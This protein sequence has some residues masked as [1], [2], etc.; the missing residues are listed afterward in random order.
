M[1]YKG[2]VIDRP[3]LAIIGE[4]IKELGCNFEAGKVYTF[5][6]RR[7]WREKDGYLIE[8]IEDAVER[9]NKKFP[10]KKHCVSKKSFRKKRW[11]TKRRTAQEKANKTFKEEHPDIPYKEQ[12][13]DKR[14]LVFRE[15]ILAK[16]GHVCE[17]CGLTEHLQIHHLRYKTR[18]YAWEYKETDVIV[19]CAFCHAKTHGKASERL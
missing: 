5:W 10:T 15:K 16:R 8:T 17:R 12:L 6:F 4:C 1:T 9:Y 18:H 7:G 14:W 19:L 11:H 3:T 2:I 13:K